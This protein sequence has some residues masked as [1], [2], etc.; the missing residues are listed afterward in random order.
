[1]PAPAR[2]PRGRRRV[3]RRALRPASPARSRRPAAPGRPPPAR[4]RRADDRSHRCAP[5]A[6]RQARHARRTAPPPRRAAARARPAA[7]SR[8]QPAAAAGAG[9]GTPPR[10]SRSPRPDGESHGADRRGRA[11]RPARGSP[12]GWR[13]AR[14]RARPRGRRPRR[15]SRRAARAAPRSPRVAA[16]PTPTARRVPR[17]RRAAPG[18]GGAC[19]GRSPSRAL[20]EA[21]RRTIDREARKAHF[22]RGQ[23]LA[24]RAVAL[25]D[26]SAD[27]HFA[28]FCNLGEL[29]RL[30]GENLT[31]VFQLRRLMA[32][33]DRTLELDPNHVDAMAAKGTL[34]V[35]LPR[36]L[37]GDSVKGEAMLRQVLLRDPN[38]FTTRLALANVCEARGNRQ[39]ALAFAARAL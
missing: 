29:M 6:R 25:D 12:R 11:R 36:L 1:A 22:D 32:E 8:G 37:G 7:P 26:N 2:R 27:A 4:G 28:L 21:G 39:E 3:S 18:G 13:A 35:R 15:R 10:R 16:P 20:C 14:A 30:D 34:L 24:E 5:R 31:Q 19:G 38:A 33:V 23:A 9:G 17:A